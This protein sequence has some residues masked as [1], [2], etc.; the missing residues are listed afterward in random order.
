MIGDPSHALFGRLR[1][2]VGAY[3]LRLT[4]SDDL[5]YIFDDQFNGAGQSA[6]SSKYSA[7]NFALYGSLDA[8][9]GARSTISG[10]LRVERRVARYSDSADA[11][12]PF[13]EGDE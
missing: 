5:T 3:G 2:L 10:G 4:E 7:T 11:L 12:T 1:W 8:D 9:V 6:L 13:P